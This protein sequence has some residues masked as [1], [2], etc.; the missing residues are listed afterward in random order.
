MKKRD[1]IEAAN[2][3]LQCKTRFDVIA[4]KW[5]DPTFNPTTT[6]SSCHPAFENKIVLFHSKVKCL[7]PADAIAIQNRLSSIR[8]ALL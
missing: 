1:E 6:V 4:D 2:S 7:L 3:P 5:N 8:A